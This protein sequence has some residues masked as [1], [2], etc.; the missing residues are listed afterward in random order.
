MIDGLFMDGLIYAT[1]SKNLSNN[2]GSTWCSHFSN[3]SYQRFYEHPPVAIILQS[4]FY[5]F[6]GEIK[7]IPKIYSII[8]F[9]IVGVLISKIWKLYV[10]NREW[11]PILIWISIPIVRWAM[12]SNLLENTM[13]IFI[14]GSIYLYLK[15]KLNNKIHLLILS[16]ILITFGFL[17]K[18]FVSL[19]P[20][21]LPVFFNL[22]Y[23]IYNFKT[24]IKESVIL[25]FS[26]SFPIFYLIHKFYNIKI[27]FINY[28]NNQVI[29]SVNNIRTVESR[30]YIIHSILFE[31]LPISIIVLL[32]FILLKT[33]KSPIVKQGFFFMFLALSGSLPI[34]IS[35][36]QSDFYII[37]VYPLFALFIA[38]IIYKK[39]SK[40]CLNF[41]QHII[42][43]IFTTAFLLVTIFF[44]INTKTRKRFYFFVNEI[45]NYNSNTKLYIPTR[46]RWGVD[47][48]DLAKNDDVY[49]I[50]NKVEKNSTIYCNKEIWKDIS[51]QGYFAFYKNITLSYNTNNKLYELIYNKKKKKYFLIK[52][53]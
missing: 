7:S 15:F 20:L 10:N 23:K 40:I 6:H 50:C 8:T 24:I 28:I 33:E 12:W 4:Y 18:G 47:K 27:F 11:L 42:I 36:K 22:F 5:N 45:N 25:F 1:L 38:M 43:K 26:F 29:N 30:F 52:P 49:K 17:T 46:V 31:L 32:F 44:S 13:S 2:I 37:A 53:K 9:L 51:L 16:G 19:F 48:N 41:R 14:L 39:I 34:I 3:S 35:M 21:I